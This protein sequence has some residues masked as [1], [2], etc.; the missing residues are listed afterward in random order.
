M[1]KRP[2]KL[3]IS[4]FVILL[5]WIL[6]PISSVSGIDLAIASITAI[7]AVNGLRKNQTILIEK[8]NSPIGGDWSF[9]KMN[10]KKPTNK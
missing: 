4:K 6:F 1:G 2:Q 9:D 8:D 10:R 5:T 7:D 3:I